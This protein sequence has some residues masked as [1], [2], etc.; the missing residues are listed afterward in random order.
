MFRYG[1]KHNGEKNKTTRVDIYEGYT[2]RGNVA[3]CL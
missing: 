3:V 1:A 2:V